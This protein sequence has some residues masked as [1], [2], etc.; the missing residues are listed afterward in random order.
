MKFDFA[1]SEKRKLGNMNVIRFHFLNKLC[2]L[3]PTDPRVK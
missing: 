3:I 1:V 2:S